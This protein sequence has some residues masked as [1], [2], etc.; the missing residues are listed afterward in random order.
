[1]H[2]LNTAALE[3][4]SLLLVA[5]DGITDPRKRRHDSSIDTEAGTVTYHDAE[6]LGWRARAA[7]CGL[8]AAG[9]G[10]RAAS[11]D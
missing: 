1:M 11:G 8:R 3:Q 7:G 4:T 2:D 10:P 9:C 6:H 5:L